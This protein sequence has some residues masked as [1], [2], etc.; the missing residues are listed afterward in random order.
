VEINEEMLTERC[1][2]V[3]LFI[4]SAGFSGALVLAGHQLTKHLFDVPGADDKAV[5][6][7]SLMFETLLLFPS[8]AIVIGA[9]VGL[10][11][12]RQRLWLAGMSL[13]PL[14]GYLVLE[15]QSIIFAAFSLV[16]VALSMA[17]AFSILHF[18]DKLNRLKQI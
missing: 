5:Y 13:T 8:I 17:S 11:E 15:S 9:F 7:S 3:L 1:R 14:L 16:Y 12:H 2:T 4:V 18:K 6:L 10:L